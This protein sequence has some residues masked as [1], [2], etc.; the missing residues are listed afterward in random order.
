MFRRL[1][2][3]SDPHSDQAVYSFPSF[4]TSNSPSITQPFLLSSLLLWF[5][6]SS[7]LLLLILLFLLLLLL[8]FILLLLLLLLL[9][10]LL[11]LLLL[12]SSLLLLSLKAVDVFIAVAVV[13]VV[14]VAIL[15]TLAAVVAV[16]FI[17]V[18]C[19]PP[20]IGIGRRCRR[21]SLLFPGRLQ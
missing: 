2:A 20:R 6:S 18:T 13:V 15:N 19:R 4:N 8:L 17:C 11:L 5:V 21:S 10:L 3:T 1:D 12:L 9:I 14:A 7:S 16:G